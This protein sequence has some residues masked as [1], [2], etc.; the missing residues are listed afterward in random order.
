MLEWRLRMWGGLL[1]CEP[2]VRCGGTVV[3]MWEA[4]WRRSTNCKGPGEPSAFIWRSSVV[5]VSSL[6]SSNGSAAIQTAAITAGVLSQLA[7]WIIRKCSWA[8][9]ST[10]SCGAAASTAPAQPVA[11]RQQP[12]TNVKSF[13]N[14]SVT[15]PSSMSLE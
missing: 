12:V 10:A 4:T 2:S 6:A 8:T 15:L 3:G 7:G 13:A 9:L 11:A 14:A 1:L 5:H